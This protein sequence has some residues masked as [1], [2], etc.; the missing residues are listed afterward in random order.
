[1]IDGLLR[2]GIVGFTAGR[3]GLDERIPE[4]K[5]ETGHVLVGGRQVVV[6]ARAPGVLQEFDRFVDLPLERLEALLTK[7]LFARPWT[8]GIARP[9]YQNVQIADI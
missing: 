2:P 5:Q 1:M 7:V 4:K 8:V 6:L 9:A 3:S